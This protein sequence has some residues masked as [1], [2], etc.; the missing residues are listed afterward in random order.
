MPMTG[1]LARSIRR[2]QHSKEQVLAI[3]IGLPA[4]SSLHLKRSLLE[5]VII[6]VKQS[7]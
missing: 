5:A 2:N 4:R 1:I 7:R 6:E 3:L